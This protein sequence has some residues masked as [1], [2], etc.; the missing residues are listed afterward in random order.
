MSDVTMRQLEYFIQTAEAGSITAAAQALHVSQSALSMS[1]GEL[2]RSLGVQLFVRQPRGMALSRAGAQVLTDARRLVAGLADL[3]NSAR[4]SQ[5]S[6]AGPLQVGCYSTL[7]PLLL[8]PVIAAF[9]E[10]HPGVHLTFVEGSHAVLEEQLRTGALDLAILY[11]YGPPLAR[12]SGD[13]AAQPILSSAPYVLLPEEHPLAAQPDVSLKDLADQ[14][15]ILFSLPPGGEY[16]LSLFSQAG[17]EPRVRFQTSSY[18][19]VRSLVARGLGYSILSQRTTTRLTYEGLPFVTRELSGNHAGLDI[20]AVTL[21][22]AQ[23][24][25][26]A[27]AF[28]AQCTRSWSQLDESGE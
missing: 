2:E 11:D 12:R 21:A 15:L 24:T 9:V 25:R 10:R 22:A 1:I 14:P 7:S 26:R 4:D 13:L 20:T 16:F 27:K 17:L 5:H 18:E 19:L 23:P 3:Q 8:P 6:L 28:V